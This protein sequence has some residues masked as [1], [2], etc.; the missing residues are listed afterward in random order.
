MKMKNNW[1]KYISFCIRGFFD[2]RGDIS[3]MHEQKKL[4]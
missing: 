2:K 1:E 3:V 4:K